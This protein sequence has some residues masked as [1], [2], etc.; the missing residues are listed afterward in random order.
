MAIVVMLPMQ[1]LWSAATWRTHFAYSDVAQIAVTDVEVFGLSDGSLY[2]VNKQTEA[3]RLWD[4]SSGLHSTDV[5]CI[6]YEEESGVLVILYKNGK[7]D[8]LEGLRGRVEGP[9]ITYVGDLYLEDMT[10]SKQANCVAF[11]G[12]RSNNQGSRLAYIGMPFGIMTFDLQKREFPNTYYI[13]SEAGEVNV[14]TIFFSGDTIYAASD[15]LLYS[16]VI[17][18][19]LVDYRVWTSAPLPTSGRVYEQWMSVRSQ[20]YQ[21]GAYTWRAAGAQGI[22]RTGMGGAIYYKPDG[23]IDNNPYRMSYQGGKLYVVPGARWAVQSWNAGQV[24]YL[25]DGRWYHITNEYIESQIGARAFDF[26]NVAAW[27]TDPDM[28]YVTSYGTGL[29]LFKDTVI[30][31][32][33]MQENSAL[34][35]AAPAVPEWYTRTD[36]IVF[37]SLGNAWMMNASGAVD[38]YICI[39]KPDGSWTNLNAYVDGAPVTFDTPGEIVISSSGDRYKWLPSCRNVTS[40]VLLDDHGTPY[41]ESDDKSYVR[42]T[43]TDQN[44][45]PVEP[46]FIYCASEDGAGGLWVGTDNGPFYIPSVADFIAS[47]GCERVRFLQGDG[48]YLMDEERVNCIRVDRYGRAWIGT[49]TQGIYVIA[50]DRQS[51][52]MHLLPG[53]DNPMPSACVLSIAIDE[54]T[55]TYYIGTGGGI[56]SYQEEGAGLN[57]SPYTSTETFDEQDYSGMM[58]AWTLHFAYQDVTQIAQSAG[59]VYG[60]SEGALFSVSRAD[61]EVRYYNRLSGLSDANISSIWFDNVT[62]LLLI[63]YVNGNMDLL[64]DEG[65]VWNIPDLRIKQLSGTAKTAGTVTMHDGYAYLAMSFGIMQVNMRRHEIAD[66]Y[67]IGADGADVDVQQIGFAGDSIYAASGSRLYAASL[68]DNLVD[69][70]VWQRRSVPATGAIADALIPTATDTIRSGGETYI[71]AGANG[72]VRIAQDGTYHT[73]VPNGPATNMPYSMTAVGDRL[74]AVPGGRWATEFQRP[75]NVMIYDKGEWFNS[76]YA[77]IKAAMDWRPVYD[78]VSAAIDPAD[79]HHFF[80]GSYG[81]GLYEYRNDVLYLHHGYYNSPGGLEK[82]AGD[83]AGDWYTRVDGLAFD[84]EGNLWMMNAGE[85]ANNV[86]ILA[87]DGSWRSFN[88][89]HGSKRI[90]YETPGPICIDAL[91]PNYKWMPSCRTSAATGAAA[92]LGLLDDNG[93]PLNHSDDRMVFYTT[94]VDQFGSTVSPDI[95]YCISQDKEGDVWIGTNEGVFAIPAGADYFAS[96]ACKRFKINRNDGSGLADFLLAK[97]SIRAIAHDGGN[98]HWFGT[99]TNGVFLIQYRDVDDVAT[100]YH[101]TTSN[102]PLPSNTI[103]SIEIQPTTGEVF[104]GT[105]SGLASFKSDAS[106]PHTNYNDAYVYPNPVRPD[107]EGNITFTGLMDETYVK[108]VDAGGNEVFFTRANG[109]TAVWN[110]C[111]ASGRKV[112]RGVYRA[113]CNTPGGGHTILKLLIMH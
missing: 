80:V 32:H 1:P 50:P 96:N 56:V 9:Q 43:W 65:D 71:A 23:P 86:C 75:G 53:G 27:P 70:H 26:M 54:T 68:R 73:Y 55:Q 81:T 14:Q 17:D 88:F 16:A 92:G 64:S 40:I 4:L 109:G 41:D 35:P 22:E 42:Y 28:F 8:L 21:D 104:I 18:S 78:F 108:V 110:G 66:T 79:P 52:E 10:A 107:Y 87:P 39:R 102:S 93:T 59:K 111:D 48:K 82:A 6:G 31:D 63:L 19:N 72:I 44:G 45:L 34:E 74:I 61:E 24:S 101:F 13:G 89:Y 90:V 3:L 84:G 85:Y 37:D 97:E 47:N 58:G 30:Q 49:Q 77:D 99:A 51:V 15:S 60:L 67:Y 2:S 69:Y 98:R 57:D 11:H 94:F 95:I 113:Y 33:W 29:Y 83:A 76:K 5:C 25:Q 103:F 112:P 7:V 46:E 106:A 12:A 38:H 62:G 105:E 20:T 36:G 100:I 91:R